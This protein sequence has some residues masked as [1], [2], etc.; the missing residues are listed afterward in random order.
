MSEKLKKEIK[1]TIQKA[2]HRTL[3]VDIHLDVV[4]D[5]E[6]IEKYPVG[7]VKIRGSEDPLYIKKMLPYI[8]EFREDTEDLKEIKCERERLIELEKLSHIFTTR[9]VS[10][11]IFDWDQDFFEQPYSEDVA[12]EIFSQDSHSQI[13]NEVAEAMQQR[14]DFLPLLSTQRGNG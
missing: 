7:W 11:A 9:T 5:N 6:E 2:L 3:K 1:F 10:V 14:V 12:L 4:I 8:K 13:Y